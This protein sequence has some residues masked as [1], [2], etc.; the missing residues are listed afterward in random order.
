MIQPTLWTKSFAP[1]YLHFQEEKPEVGKT[2]E[3]E[4]VVW[5]E[6]AD[7][8]NETEVMFWEKKIVRLF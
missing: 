8:Q 5:Q 4:Y 6:I 2:G 1:S 3:K 7:I